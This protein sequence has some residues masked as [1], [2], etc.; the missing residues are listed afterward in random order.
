MIKGMIETEADEFGTRKIFPP[1]QIQ[2]VQ[3]H[4]FWELVTG[5][6]VHRDGMEIDQMIMDFYN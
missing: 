3:N 5:R 2:I 1:I 6:L 4:G